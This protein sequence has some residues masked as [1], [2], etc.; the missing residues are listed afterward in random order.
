M[1]YIKYQLETKYI[2]VSSLNQMYHFIDKDIDFLKWYFSLL[3]N[4]I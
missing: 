4:A 1:G 3:N 2:Y